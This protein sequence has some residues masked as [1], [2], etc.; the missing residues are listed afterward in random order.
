MI[1]APGR[2][3]RLLLA[4]LL[5]AGLTS[6][7]EK[8]VNNDSVAVEVTV[9]ASLGN[10]NQQGNDDSI[11][12]LGD[13]SAD[14]RYIV[15]A[16]KASNLVPGDTNGLPDVFWRDM[17][18][19]TTRL[20]SV[21]L[22]GTSGN[23]GS[24]RP[25]ISA[26][27][28]VV[29]FQS[30]ATDMVAGDPVDAIID[31]YVW[32]ADTGVVSLVSRSSGP[33]GAKGDGHSQNPQISGNGNFVVFQSDA[34]NLDGGPGLGDDDTITDIYRRELF[35]AFTT[36]IVSRAS[37]VGGAKGIGTSQKPTVSDDG[38]YVAFESVSNNLVDVVSQGGADTNSASDVFVRDLVS[39][40]TERVSLTSGDLEG[41]GPGGSAENGF[42]S[43]DGS[44]VAF[45]SSFSN[46]VPQDSSSDSDIFV[47]DR[48]AG[49]TE[50]STVHTSGAQAGQNCNFPTISGDG[51]YVVWQSLS[52]SLVNGDSNAKSD[53]FMHDR[54]LATTLRVSVT[55][56]GGEM[57]GE[58]LKAVVSADGRYVMF[59]CDATNAADDDTNGSADIYLR[60]PPF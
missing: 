13:L 50:I 7:C 12:E 43:G 51:R 25:S 60:G 44:A 37:G 29:A 20:V 52:S 59:W 3:R 49:T 26:D 47:R 17:V 35:G 31:V 32:N 9:R 55:T 6:G 18:S 42:I 27:G 39:L 57:N 45:R 19:R 41:S 22:A 46:L 24:S 8:K 36:T 34:I 40:S 10:A 4:L 28:K 48:V 5:P 23:S 33:G 11:D 21:S 15:F 56:Y 54:V 14:G 58:S 16:S 30:L 53:T 1:H 38:R 2:I